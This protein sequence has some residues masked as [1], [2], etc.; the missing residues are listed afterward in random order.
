MAEGRSGWFHL[1]LTVLLTVLSVVATLAWAQGAEDAKRT[2]MRDSVVE[3]TAEVKHLADSVGALSYNTAAINAQVL[4]H[5][6]SLDNRIDRVER[7]Q[8]GGK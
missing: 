6:H 7:H 4:E 2:A 3:L 8:D 1:A 5:L